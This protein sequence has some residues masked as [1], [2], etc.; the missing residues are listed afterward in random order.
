[1]V[2]CTVLTWPEVTTLTKEVFPEALPDD[3]ECLP[4]KVMKVNPNL[5]T[6]DGY[7]KLLGEEETGRDG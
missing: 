7:L 5:Q 3:K 2:S 1:M 4:M 6:Y